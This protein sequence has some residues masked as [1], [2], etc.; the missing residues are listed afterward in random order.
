VLRVRAT[1]VDVPL[2]ISING[3][4]TSVTHV[5]QP[6]QDVV[7]PLSPDEPSTIVV[8][9]HAPVFVRSVHQPYPEGIVVDWLRLE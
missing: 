2:R 3:A 1:S 5:S 9:I 4:H 7:V 6:W 8:E